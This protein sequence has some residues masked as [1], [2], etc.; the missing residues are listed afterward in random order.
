MVDRS[1]DALQNQVFD[2]SARNAAL[3]ER[4][5]DLAGGTGG[6][7]LHD[8]LMQVRTQLA[9]K[10]AELAELNELFC[11]LE[12][13]TAAARSERDELRGLLESERGTASQSASDAT[14][15][16]E[17]VDKLAASAESEARGRAAA[18]PRPQVWHQ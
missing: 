10:E 18:D 11:A 3:Q 1:E 16:L 12:N 5:A 6:I 14:S 17:R 15:A 7:A 4:L 2:L 13:D 9:G 8:E